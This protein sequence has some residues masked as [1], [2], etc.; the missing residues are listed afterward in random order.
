MK[1]YSPED[2]VKVII[3]KTR[4]NRDKS[5]FIELAEIQSLVLNCIEK[6]V[7][8][9]L[10]NSKFIDAC[11]TAYIGSLHELAKYYNKTFYIR[12][13]KESKLANYYI[14]SG[15]DHYFMPG[16]P[17]PS[18]PNAIYFKKFSMIDEGYQEDIDKILELAPV[19]LSDKARE[20]LFTNI[21]EIFQNADEHSK[22]KCGVYGCGQW[23]P[24]R[25]ELTFSIYDTG[26][27]IVDTVKNF[28][29]HS[30]HIN[31]SSENAILWALERGTSTEQL[32]GN[33]PRGVGLYNLIQFIDINHG[34]ISI[35]TNDIYLSRNSG[36][37][38]I[39][40][41][42]HAIIGTMINFTIVA[43]TSRKYRL[44]TEV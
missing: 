2:G 30:L 18:N 37:N 11:F 13:L 28:H 23:F 39:Y 35:I 10:T 15:L 42:N 38:K 25:N 32:V 5:S 21:Y 6:T 1:D 4:L 9:D 14:N 22:E 43:D 44:T 26:N 31:I 20:F 40:T 33:V 34:D 27:G 3:P 36:K 7:Y 19:T 41:L 17:L 8:L 12:V 29:K 24:K 16:N